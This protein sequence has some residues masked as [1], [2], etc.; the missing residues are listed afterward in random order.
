VVL[1]NLLVAPCITKAQFDSLKQIPMQLNFNVESNYDGEG[2]Y[3]REAVAESLQSWCQ[4]NNIDLY[5]DGLKIY[6]TIDTRM[7]KYAEEAVDK[8]MRVVQRNFNT[9]GDARIRGEIKRDK[10]FLIS[11]RTWQNALRLINNW[12]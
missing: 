3:F 8:Q 4:E 11:L 5:A 6:T 12:N 9:T 10:R 1:D 2:L 7:Q